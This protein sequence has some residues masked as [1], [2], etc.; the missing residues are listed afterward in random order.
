MMMMML[1]LW[2]VDDEAAAAAARWSTTT[3]PNANQC[4]C[5]LSLSL[6]D[7]AFPFLR[8]STHESHTHKHSSS[9]LQA[10]SSSLFWRKRGEREKGATI[11]SDKKERERRAD[12][13]SPEHWLAL[14]VAVVDAV[15]A[16]HGNTC[17]ANEGTSIMRSCC[18]SFSSSSSN[19]SSNTIHCLPAAHRCNRSGTGRS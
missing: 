8:V 16:R 2:P 17:R 18:R 15:A 14:V 13:L 9:S 7:L 5:S 12:R 1:L 10:L 11:A 19:S 4:R 3:C 6:S